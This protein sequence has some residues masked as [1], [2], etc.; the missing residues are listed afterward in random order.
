[1][2]PHLHLGGHRLTFDDRPRIMGI[3]NVN[4]DSAADGGRYFDRADPGPAIA[5]GLELV[6]QGADLIDVGGESAWN[7]PVLDPAEEIARV[8]PVIAGLAVQVGVPISVDTYKPEV[9]RAAVA[10]GASLINDVS[11]FKD[12]RIAS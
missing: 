6:A 1:M 2:T 5:R 4:P 3:L 8:V 12:E 9:A 7:S 10:A 11:G